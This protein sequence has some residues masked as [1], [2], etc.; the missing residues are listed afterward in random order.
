MAISAVT[1][2][3]PQTVPV[4]DPFVRIGHWTLVIAFVVAYVTEDE[5]LELHEWAGYIVGAYVLARIA[6]GVVGPAHAR[7]ADFAYSPLKATTYLVALLRGQAE[8]YLGHS[9]A[10][11]MMVFALL[12]ALSGTVITGMAELA[13]SHGEGPLSLVLDRGMPAPTLDVARADDGE[14]A[15]GRERGEHSALGEVHELFANLTLILIVFHVAGVVVAS[16][17]HK[18]SL[19]LSMITGRKRPNT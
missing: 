6:W 19:V 17:S 4:W 2:P 1:P 5:A 14:A 13:S 8:R 16:I 10:G 7:F 11:A 3:A 18:E 15:E 9:P 12:L